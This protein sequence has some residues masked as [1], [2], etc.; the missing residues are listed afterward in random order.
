MFASFPRLSSSRSRRSSRSFGTWPGFTTWSVAGSIWAPASTSCPIWPFRSEIC[1]RIEFACVMSELISVSSFAAH[2]RE[3]RRGVVERARQRLAGLR[4][5]LPRGQRLRVVGD[6]VPGVEEVLHQR[7]H[8]VVRRLRDRQRDRVQL[9]VA[10]VERALVGHRGAQL[11]VV[12]DVADAAVRVDRH[13]LAH[14]AREDHP[15]H[16]DVRDRVGR[17]E[18]GLLARV[19]LGVGVRDVV[20]R[21]VERALL[22]DQ[23]AHRD[24]D[25]VEGR[26][27][28]QARA[29]RIAIGDSW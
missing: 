16:R 25:P 1:C 3:R 19:A 21:R 8:A 9:A 7:L 15:P 18:H 26:D 5:R 29:S 10:D 11:H 28:H 22:R 2:L 6:V 23:A 24:V 17:L 14:L 12:E 4:E 27:T 13:A 20:R